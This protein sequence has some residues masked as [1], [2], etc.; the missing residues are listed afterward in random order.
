MKSN[1]EKYIKELQDVKVALYKKFKKSNY[2]TL[3]DFIKVK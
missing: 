1:Y 3:K 2:K